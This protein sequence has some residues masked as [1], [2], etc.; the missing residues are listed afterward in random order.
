MSKTPILLKDEGA[1]AAG[2]LVREFYEERGGELKRR[3]KV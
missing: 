1:T 2:L 3:K